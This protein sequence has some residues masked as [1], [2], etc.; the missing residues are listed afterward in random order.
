MFIGA[1]TKPATFVSV[2]S[3]IHQCHTLVHFFFKVMWD[4]FNTQF[5]LCTLSSCKKCHP[6][7]SLISLF[8]ILVAEARSPE[9]FD[10]NVFT[11]LFLIQ[12]ITSEGK[13][14]RLTKE[15]TVDLISGDV[16]YYMRRKANGIRQRW[17]LCWIF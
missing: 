14:G 10:K 2:M 7:R 16:F 9:I 17:G 8:S 13:I 12:L 6:H 11:V 1:F 3:Q 4:I 15:E 5:E